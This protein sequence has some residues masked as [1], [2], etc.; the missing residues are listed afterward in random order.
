MTFE[1]A[2]ANITVYPNFSALRGYKH[3]LCDCPQICEDDHGR[4]A[5]VSE[6]AKAEYLEICRA[7]AMG[8]YH[9]WRGHH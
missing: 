9:A 7:K 6:A 8:K 3:R 1:E 5:Y 2:M 4:I